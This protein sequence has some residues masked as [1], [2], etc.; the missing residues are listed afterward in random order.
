MS[1]SRRT[2]VGF[3]AAG[4]ALAV[5]GC[6][7]K[8]PAAVNSPVP[9]E[10]S[11]TSSAMAT[12]GAVDAVRFTTSV[13]DGA[14][15]PV[16]TVLT[17]TA[18]KGSLTDVVMT[19]TDPKAGQKKVQGTMAPDN[20]T[21]TAG[22]L[23]EPGMA[24]QVVVTGHNLTGLD[25]TTTTTFSSQNLSLKQQIFPTI[26]S[27]GTVGVA[28]PV[29]VK[30]D[31]P[32]T[33]RAAFQKHMTVTS[34][35]PQEGSWGWQSS[36]EAHW[37]PKELWKP[38]TQVSI[39][40]DINSIPAGKGTYGQKSVTGTMTIGR[41]V[42]LNADLAAHSMQVIIDGAVAK[43]IPITGGKAGFLTRSGKKVLKEK[44]AALR[45]NSET[46]GIPS[47]SPDFYDLSN[48]QYAM[49][50]TDSGEFVHAAPWSVGSQGVANV[51]HGCIGVSTDNGAWLFANCKVGDLINVTGTT[52]TLEKGNGW[53]DWNVS[54]DEF[55]KDSAL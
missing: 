17:V 3:A 31:V 51:S 52:R 20:A 49:R 4:S 40:V 32:V 33:D 9:S 53:T 6:A 8:T 34:N 12:Q 25:A 47:T 35:P 43:S 23:L 26:L 55:R 29:I 45:M 21:W 54:Y 14:T 11:P 41:S 39:N 16:D 24:Y 37:R 30:F 28:M 48:V 10:P 38:G 13:A 15:V 22:S 19:Y 7:V 5:A 2:V 46:V 1:V 42:V 44:F 27:G 36:T 50:E 18:E